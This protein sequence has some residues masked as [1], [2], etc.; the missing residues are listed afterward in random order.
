[1]NS[2]GDTVSAD[3]L[4]S[5]LRDAGIG[6]AYVARMRERAR[7][8]SLYRG[9]VPLSELSHVIGDAELE[10]RFLQSVGTGRY[11]PSLQC[12]NCGP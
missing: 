6:T 11:V 8:R 1:M 10:H 2:I 12:A 7:N 9:R 4:W 5:F 3:H